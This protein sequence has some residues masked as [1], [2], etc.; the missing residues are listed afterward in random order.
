M[1]AWLASVE[2]GGLLVCHPGD[3]P[4][5][6][7]DPIAPARAPELA[8]LGSDAFLADL[9]EAGVEPVRVRSLARRIDPGGADAGGS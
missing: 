9:A 8:Y 6:P 4:A 2:D 3:T 1:R 7:G 5:D